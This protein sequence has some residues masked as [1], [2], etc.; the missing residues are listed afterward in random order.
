[1]FTF[2]EFLNERKVDPTDLAIRVGR[3]YGKKSSFG[4]WEK[5][6][7]GGHIPLTSFNTRKT[8]SLATKEEKIRDRLSPEDFEKA[9]VKKKMEIKDLNATQKYVRTDDVDKLR[10]KMND[11]AASHIRVVTHKGEHYVDDG[12]HAVMAAVMRGEKTVL[13][14][15]IDLD[16]FKNKRK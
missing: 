4:K 6:T 16:Q 13:V 9:H 14:S 15:N 3:R 2:A 12:H 1:M 11:K 8:E 5:V 10:A 7:K